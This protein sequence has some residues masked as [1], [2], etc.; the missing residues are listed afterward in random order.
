MEINDTTEIFIGAFQ[1]PKNNKALNV[2]FKIILEY[3]P[4]KKNAK[5]TAEYST[6]YPATNSASASGKSKGGL[7]VSANPEIINKK[8]TGKNGIKNQIFSCKITI[9]VRLKEPTNKIKL[10]IIKPIE[11]S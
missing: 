3:S 11:T 9:F 10:I 7:L 4:I 8:K 5:L 6:I 1:P 2:L